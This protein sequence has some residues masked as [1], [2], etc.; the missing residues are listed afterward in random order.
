MIIYVRRNSASWTKQ[1][2]SLDKQWQVET[3]VQ[4]AHRTEAIAST[5]T[6]SRLLSSVVFADSSPLPSFALRSAVSAA[7]VLLQTISI[8]RQ[9]RCHS[10]LSYRDTLLVCAS[11]VP[12]STRRRK[13]PTL[14]DLVPASCCVVLL[15][16]TVGTDF[17]PLYPTREINPLQTGGLPTDRSR[18]IFFR[19]QFCYRRENER[20][21]TV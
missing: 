12:S 21:L 7:F 20:L 10:L 1:R 11:R 14:R 2:R 4:N 3:L 19:F 18:F 6:L 9:P 17:I 13:S 15:S 8:I 16:D 5:A